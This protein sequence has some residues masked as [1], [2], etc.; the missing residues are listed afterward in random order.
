MLADHDYIILYRTF[1]QQKFMLGDGSGK[2]KQREL[3]YLGNLIE[4]KSRVKLSISTL[5]RLWRN[6]IHQLPHPST[7]DALVSILE[8]KDWQDFK[9]QNVNTPSTSQAP[10]SETKNKKVIRPVPVFVAL[11][12][13]VLIVGFFI[14]QGFNKKNKGVIVSK[15][16]LF[17]ADKTVTSGVPNTVMFHYDLSGVEADSFFIQ[18]SWNPRDKV[19]IDPKKN[20]YSDIY[21][22]PGFHFARVMA[23]DSILKFENVHIKTEG[24]LPLVKYDIRDKK[25]M[26]LDTN[27]IRGNGAMRTTSEIL[28]KANVDVN[29]DF[30]LRYY[31]IRDFDGITSANFNLETRIKCDRLSFDGR[32][33]SVVCPLMEIMLITE[34][35]VFFIPLTSKGCVSELDLLV[36]E[37]YKGGKDNDLSSL[38]TD[39][40]SWQ[41][42]QVK[43]ENKN[44]TIFLNGSPVH[45]LQYKKD[46]GK[47]KGIIYTFTGSGSVDFLRF[48][49]MDGTVV[50]EDEF[51]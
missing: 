1:V 17:S 28:H 37:V 25:H 12:T 9:K 26:Y 30:Y 29:K 5:K 23:N 13:I 36:G 8:Y 35:N 2:L 24:W 43:N 7:L 40:Y 45:E 44:V 49:N 14:L 11:G 3:E 48:K 51:E 38:G 31:N 50:Y 39:V 27:S 10:Q 42:L 4:E 46:F 22:T 15:D 41:S 18:Q 6:D 32:T 20:Y 16:V 33:T 21:Y 34:E 19:R 47:I